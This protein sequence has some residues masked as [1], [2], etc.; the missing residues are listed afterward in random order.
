MWV[1]STSCPYPLATAA[2]PAKF[3]VTDL[4]WSRMT[5]DVSSSC[6][7]YRTSVSLF[8]TS[9]WRVNSLWQLMSRVHLRGAGM[10]AAVTW[11]E[12]TGPY[13]RWDEV[14]FC[15]AL[16]GCCYYQCKFMRPEVRQGYNS[17]A[18]S[19][20]QTSAYSP[21]TFTGWT[22]GFLMVSVENAACCV[23]F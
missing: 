2:S 21:W 14:P 9:S 7:S 11:R 4:C 6:L 18:C 23:L 3:W 8:S 12:P 10:S 5:P 20:L 15:L 22:D 1:M 17:Q 13:C 19:A 16:Y